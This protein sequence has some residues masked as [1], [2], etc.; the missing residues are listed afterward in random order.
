[1]QP[2]PFDDPVSKAVSALSLSAPSLPPGLQDSAR[3]STIPRLANPLPTHN[4]Q[5]SPPLYQYPYERSGGASLQNPA[6]QSS[7]TNPISGA[8]QTQP[9]GQ[10]YH[11][12]RGTPA[13]YQPPRLQQSPYSQGAAPRNESKRESSQAEPEEDFIVKIG[14]SVYNATYD[15]TEGKAKSVCQSMLSHHGTKY[16]GAPGLVRESSAHA[17]ENYISWKAQA[18]EKAKGKEKSLDCSSSPSGGSNPPPQRR[19]LEAKEGG[20]AH[21]YA[22]T[23]KEKSKK[24]DKDAG[25]SKEKGKKDEKTKKDKKDDK[26]RQ[27]P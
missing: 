8:N 11:I 12:D 25:G 6:R 20:R 18:R 5:S 27:R 14:A 26:K 13:Y 16:Y 2:T 3:G 24:E 7:Y 10:A 21:S 4:T 19:R 22:G 9:Q 15:Y 1:M 17:I 23:G